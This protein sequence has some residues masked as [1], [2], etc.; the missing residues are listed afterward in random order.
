MPLHQRQRL[1][2]DRKG[3]QD[4]AQVRAQPGQYPAALRHPGPYPE[5]VQ[6]ALLNLRMAGEVHG[7]DQ[8][9]E[10]KRSPTGK[11]QPVIIQ[12]AQHADV[13]GHHQQQRHGFDKVG[14]ARRPHKQTLQ[15]AVGH[16][17]KGEERMVFSA[18]ISRLPGSFHAQG[19]APFRAPSAAG[20]PAARSRA[21]PETPPHPGG[22]LP[23]HPAA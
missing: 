19:L 17:H 9:K 18:H 21:P 14:L 5:P 3:K 2:A 8:A 10:R 1:S 23:A 4:I 11:T 22:V 12:S 7:P 6:G 20:G 15:P 13:V 16:H